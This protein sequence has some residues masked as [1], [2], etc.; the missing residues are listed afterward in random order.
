MYKEGETLSCSNSITPPV[1]N[2]Y[3]YIKNEDNG[4]YSCHECID[5]YFFVKNGSDISCEA[6]DGNSKK[7]NCTLYELNPDGSDKKYK[8]IECVNTDS[9][10]F[11]SNTEYECLAKTTI[12]TTDDNCYLF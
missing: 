8:C 3:N 10:V 7:T 4:T 9:L 5:K 2:C 1:T 11:T 6:E 12:E